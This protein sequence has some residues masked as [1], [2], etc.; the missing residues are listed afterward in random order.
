M[1]QRENENKRK[2]HSRKYGIF[3]LSFVKQFLHF[4]MNRGLP[5]SIICF[6]FIQNL[7]TDFDDFVF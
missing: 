1:G 7:N 5:S 2:K 3:I 4:L 6:N